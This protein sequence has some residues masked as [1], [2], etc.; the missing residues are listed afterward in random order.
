MDQMKTNRS[1]YHI[2]EWLGDIGG[3]SDAL[4]I[5]GNF[6]VLPSGVFALESSLLAAI[7]RHRKSMPK[8]TEDHNEAPSGSKPLMKS[9]TKS[10]KTF[11]SD[12]EDGHDGEKE[13]AKL[14]KHDF[15]SIE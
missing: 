2:L 5:I 3:L 1:T 6:L 12:G 8:P 11:E 9:I 15:Y 4:Y 10:W 13:L 7:F 14:L